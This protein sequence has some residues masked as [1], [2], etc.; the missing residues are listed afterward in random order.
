MN[1]FIL[2]DHL[3]ETDVLEPIREWASAQYVRFLRPGEVILDERI[4]H[5]LLELKQPTFV[6]I[7]GGFWDRR[8]CHPRYCILYFALRDDQQERLPQ[9]LRSLVRKPEF[10]SR[11][12][13]MGRVVRVSSSSIEYWAF[14]QEGLCQLPWKAPRRRK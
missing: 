6:T 5:L 13:R 7:D 4:P 10:R 8:W 12:N 9:L 11:A 2:D 14:R 3:P 1:Q